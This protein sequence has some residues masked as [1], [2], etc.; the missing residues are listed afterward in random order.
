[1]RRCML[2]GLVVLMAAAGCATD[3]EYEKSSAENRDTL[4]SVRRS[5]NCAYLKVV[6][7]DALGGWNLDDDDAFTSGRWDVMTSA[8]NRSRSVG[9]PPLSQ[10]Q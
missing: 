9:C 3:A 1:M 2:I 5:T 8:E 6:F 7:F 4:A 10:R